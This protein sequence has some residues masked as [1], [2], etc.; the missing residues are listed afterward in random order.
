MS[1]AGCPMWDGRSRVAVQGSRVRPPRNNNILF[2][3]H[4][5]DMCVLERVQKINMFNTQT[6]RVRAAVLAKVTNTSVVSD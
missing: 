2:F 5:I 3:M 4:I 6:R 1:A